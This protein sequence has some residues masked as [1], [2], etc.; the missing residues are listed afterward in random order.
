MVSAEL[1]DLT[2]PDLVFVQMDVPWKQLSSYSATITATTAATTNNTTTANTIITA[3]TTIITTTTTTTPTTKART[4][5][6]ECK[7]QHLE[8]YLSPD[9][10]WQLVQDPVKE[11]GL[12]AEHEHV[13]GFLSYMHD[14]LLK[15]LTQNCWQ[16]YWRTT[17]I[18]YS[19]L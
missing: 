17:R 14:N 15:F 2:W 1:P 13:Q 18:L 4:T 10:Q 19:C 12:P 6:I 3:T 7:T 16:F 8:T 5:D 9:D 11:E